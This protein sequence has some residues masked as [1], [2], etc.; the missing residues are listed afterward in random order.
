MQL[1]AS[2]PRISGTGVALRAAGATTDWVVL[3]SV[4]VRGTALSLA[5]GRVDVDSVEVAGA[6]V[7]AWREAD[8]RI[9]L[10]QLLPA[11]PASEPA[12]ETAAAAAAP[13]Q[14]VAGDPPPPAAA[15]VDWNVAVKR[16]AL[17][18]ARIAFEDRTVRPAVAFVIAP[19]SVQASDLGLDLARPVPL[20]VEATLDGATTLRA[21]GALVPDTLSG[22]FDVA[23]A[24]LA[25]P[26]LQPYLADVAA[27]DV[28]A[29]TFAATG[30]ARLAAPGEQPRLR[31]TGE[32]GV[33]GLRAVD[34][35]QKEELVTWKQLDLA[36]VE[37][38]VAPDALRIQRMTVRQPFLRAVVAPDQSVNLLR[39]MSPVPAGT[40]P[41]AAPP[42]AG[43]AMPP[44]RIDDIRLQSATLDFA[45]LNIQPNF[46]A[47]VESLDGSIRGLSTA[48][49]SRA[50]VDLS[51]FVVNKFSPVTI[52]GELNP[53]RYDQHTDLKMAFRNIDLPVFNPYSGRYAGF[54]I[55]KGKLTTELDYTIR[56]RQLVAGH[57]V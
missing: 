46:R 53:F 29:G 57:R 8:G 2:L 17:S 35:A 50:R 24:G 30:K 5:G 25:L 3:P 14:A 41:A 10:E 45:D 9:N 22:E 27:V 56:D 54:A 11:T 42:A 48:P 16:F 49:S 21:Q 20:L 12:A 6:E 44:V 19:L 4:E 40:A 28:T 1:E 36:G 23:V 7:T 38:A 26:K 37:L 33:A 52:Q 39:V 34:R 47:R 31:F 51:G 55:A 32:A 15:P 43:A 13:A 18:D